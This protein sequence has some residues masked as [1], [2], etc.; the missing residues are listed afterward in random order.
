M[1]KIPEA[2]I[3]RVACVIAGNVTER[4]W[5]ANP[6]MHGDY[7][8]YALGALEAAGVGELVEKATAVSHFAWTAVSADCQ[9]SRDY[10][11]A[12]LCD[13]RAALAKFGAAP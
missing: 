1:T 3:K 9:E 6:D 7:L 11:N 2:M 13:L 12:L 8:E 10:L 5:D 4:Q